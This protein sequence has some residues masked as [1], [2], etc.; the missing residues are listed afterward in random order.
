MEKTASLQVHN[1]KNLW[2]NFG[3]AIGIDGIKLVQKILEG[4]GQGQGQANSESDA[5]SWL[6]NTMGGN[7]LYFSL[8]SVTCRAPKARALS[9]EKI[10]PI[11]NS[12]LLSYLDSRGTPVSV[13]SKAT[14]QAT[15]LN[16]NTDKRFSAIA[17]KNEHNGYEL[18]NPLF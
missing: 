5:I 10:G 4:Q 8:K 15:V 14:P 9:I 18:T 2:F 17:W 13:A 12:R 11:Q 16:S 6:K 3:E 7:V 1:D